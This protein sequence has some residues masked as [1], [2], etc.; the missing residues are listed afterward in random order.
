M[1]IIGK[2][3]L[4]FIYTLTNNQ[5]QC[6]ACFYLPFKISNACNRNQTS[7]HHFARVNSQITSCLFK[8]SHVLSGIL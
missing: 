4:L 8:Y 5:Y 1:E 6:L 2:S 3:K 7:D